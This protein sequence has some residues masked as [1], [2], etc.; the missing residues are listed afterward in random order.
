MTEVKEYLAMGGYALY[1]WPA[2]LIAAVV[3]IG[4]AVSS[5][6]RLTESQRIA[7]ELGVGQRHRG[8]RSGP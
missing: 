7:R 4:L 8:K 6:R 2:F 3:M 5:Y 1:V